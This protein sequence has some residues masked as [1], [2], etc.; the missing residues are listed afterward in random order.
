VR[1]KDGPPIRLFRVSRHAGIWCVLRNGAFLAD[2]GSQAE[3]VDAAYAAAK[4]EAAFGHQVL[5][6]TAS[7]APL[8]PAAAP[9]G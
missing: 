2:Y 3:A 8:V 5:V 4:K 9:H 7:G 6:V 1:P